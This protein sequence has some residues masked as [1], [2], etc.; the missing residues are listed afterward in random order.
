MTGQRPHRPD[1]SYRAEP[2]ILPPERS[3]PGKR[4]SASWSGAFVDERGVRRVYVGKIG[5][6]G[7]IGCSLLVGVVAAATLILMLGAVVLLIPLAGLLVGA[8]ALAALAR[9]YSRRS[10]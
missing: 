4:D 8:A 5:P 2:E 9:A 3:H 6:L 10:H 1:E 7:L